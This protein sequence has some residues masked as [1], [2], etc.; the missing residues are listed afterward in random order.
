MGTNKQSSGGR[1][2]RGEVVQKLANERAPLPEIFEG[3]FTLT[4]WAES[5]VNNVPYVEPDPNYLSRLL[6]TQTL[7]AASM[8]EVFAQ[9]GV[10]KLQESVPNVPDAGTG[11]IF[12]D[13]LYIATSDQE[14]GMPCYMI[15]STT[16]ME[17]G[18]EAKYTTGAGQLQAQILAAI[19]F[20]TWPIPCNIKRIDR[21]DRGGRY[22]FWMYPPE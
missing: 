4:A 18:E 20:G 8:D 13:D 21:K 1:V 14:D 22:L 6:I 19:S 12:I 7:T 16:H 11:P 3:K 17:T 5:I 10:R 2:S 15:M 9:R